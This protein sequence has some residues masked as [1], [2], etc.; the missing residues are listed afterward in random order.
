MQTVG[1]ITPFTRRS[2]AAATLRRR[3]ARWAYLL[4]L[5]NTIG[6][7][8]FFFVP[9]AAAFILGFTH[10]DLI[11]SPQWAGLDNYR[12][13]VHD[14]LFWQSLW[15]TVYYTIITVPI[16]TFLALLLAVALNT[17]LRER[18]VYRTAY[19][20][21]WVTMTVAIALVWRWIFDWQSPGLIDGLLGRLGLPQAQWL[22]DPATAMPAMMIMGVWKLLGYNMIIFLAGLQG[23]SKEVYEAARI[24]GAGRINTFFRITLP[25]VSPAT[26]F[27]LIISLISSFQVFDQII[28]MTPD[29]GPSNATSVLSLMIY[30]NAFR[31]A[32][33]GYATSIAWALFALVLFVTL[34]Q[35]ISQKWWVH[36]ADQ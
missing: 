14:P 10:W 36:Y 28:I 4:I 11:T 15:N 18:V 13:L 8:Y 26:F 30:N 23:I 19:F 34:F 2:G 32:K 6:L 33:M 25:L 29:G 31:Y 9:V 12:E 17:G 35:L 5:P 22:D 7:I 20:L 24:D 21:P 1:W 16:G 27:V 3:E